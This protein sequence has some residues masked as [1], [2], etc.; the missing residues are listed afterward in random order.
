MLKTLLLVIVAIILIFNFKSSKIIF[1]QFHSYEKYCHLFTGSLN[2][3]D[4][5]VCKH[6]DFITNNSSNNNCDRVVDVKCRQILN[7]DGEKWILIIKILTLKV[8]PTQTQTY[9]FTL[10]NADDPARIAGIVRHF[11]ETNRLLRVEVI[12]SD[13]QSAMCALAYVSSS[14]AP[15]EPEP[16]LSFLF[17]NH[18]TL[19]LENN[20][21]E[22]KVVI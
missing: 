10:D 21:F 2:N 15:Q 22:N 6:P 16:F 1:Q 17:Q 11:E 5:C 9:S 20:V 19:C 8:P 7:A 14:D 13:N 12:P 4:D 18:A 3:N